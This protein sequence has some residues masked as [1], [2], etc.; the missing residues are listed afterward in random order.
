M[1]L[2]GGGLARDHRQWI[3][4]RRSF[5]LPVKALGKVFRGKFVAGLRRLPQGTFEF[6]RTASTH[7]SAE[8]LRGFPANVVSAKLGCLREAAV[9]RSWTGSA[10]SRTLHSPRRHL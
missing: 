4:S 8:A 7:G 3:H 10:L 9:R 1:K 5:F 6:L 2:R